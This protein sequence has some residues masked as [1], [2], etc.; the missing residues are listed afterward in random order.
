MGD[1]DTDRYDDRDDRKRVDEEERFK[2][3]AYPKSLSPELG[4]AISEW[5]DQQWPETEEGD[6][7]DLPP[8]EASDL[9]TRAIERARTLEVRQEEQDARDRI[10]SLAAHRDELDYQLEQVRTTIR[11]FEAT[12]RWLERR[13]EWLVRVLEA[14]V[15]SHGTVKLRDAGSWGLGVSLTRAKAVELV[16]INQVPIE[17]LRLTVMIRQPETL[18]LRAIEWLTAQEGVSANY[19][20]RRQEALEHHK[21]TGE[22]PPGLDIVERSSVRITRPRPSKSSSP[23]TPS[24]SQES[25]S[26]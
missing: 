4:R 19:E 16:D 23:K 22:I 1:E 5:I 3:R 18:P 6:P 13:R 25:R 8:A 7:A 10:C 11:T 21:Q 9:L 24:N 15:R 14:L 17:W 26:A 2:R 20:V 12:R